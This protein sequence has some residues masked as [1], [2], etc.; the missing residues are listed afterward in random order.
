[1]NKPIKQHLI[2]PEIC[3]RCYTCEMTCPINAIEHNDDNVVVNPDICNHCMDCI[4]VCPTGSIDEWRVVMEPY[5]LDQ[6]YEWEELPEQEEIAE[7][8]D[9]VE[10]LDDAISALLAEAHQGV[11]GKAKAPA[12]AAKPSVNMYNLGKPAIATV[13]GNY[14]LTEDPD[15]DVRHIILSFGDQPFPALE[16]QSIGIIPPGEDAEGKAHLPRLYSIASPRDGER[17]Q[18]NN[19]ALTVKREEGGLA[20]NYICDLEQGAEVKVTGPF[21]ATFLMPNDAHA[22][23]V[24]ICTGTGSAPFRAMTMRRQRT[25]AEP[26]AM[27]LYFGARSPEAL[28]YFGPLKKVPDDVL[29]KRFAFS[30]VEGAEKTYVQDRMRED[31]AHLAPLLADPETYIYVCGLRGMEAGVEEALTEIASASGLDWAAL[32]D[33]MLSDGRYHTETY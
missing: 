22:K 15:H 8:G 25:G 4:P 17:P 7:G 33:A 23:L 6:Q 20:S 18:Y 9:S 27:T 32:R 29:A 24:M 2:D 31:A 1:M 30:R 16:G 21:G 3:I 12:S 28:P 19:V 13:Q 26:G 5:S 14:R 11:Q 10:A